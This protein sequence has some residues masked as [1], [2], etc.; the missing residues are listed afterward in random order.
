MNE[1]NL[2]LG[3]YKLLFQAESDF[4]LPAYAGS[5][6]RGLFGHA[7]KQ[8]VCVTREPECSRCLLYRSCVYSYIF[9]TP[10]PSDAEVMRK[11]NAVPH[12]FV[13]MPDPQQSTTV[14][15]GDSLTVF[16]SLFG[17]A[18]QHL[19]Y[20]L[21]SFEKAGARGL[22]SSKGLFSVKSLA[23]KST[24]QWQTVFE[25]GSELMALPC[26]TEIPPICPQG[27]VTLRFNTPLRLRLQNREVT[28]SIFRFS[29]LFSVVLRRASMLQQFHTE[30]PLQ[31]DFKAL[32]ES[33]KSV[34]LLSNDLRWHDWSRY[35]SRQKA[36]VKMGGLVGEIALDGKA[37]EPFWNILWL[38]QRTHAGKGTVMGL[39]NYEIVY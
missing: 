27:K 3:Q 36:P 18:N 16:L 21:Y 22:G 31:V 25:P 33:A 26:T 30:Q 8:T 35:S 9:E 14:N 2:P 23:Q 17:T 20:I 7:L 1:T 10:P 12:P 13:L 15:K 5:A 34:E 11:Y 24:D 19:P 37:L 29:A 38:G 32:S 28:A 4:Q 6:W 39:G